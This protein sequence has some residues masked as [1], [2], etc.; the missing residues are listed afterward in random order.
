MFKRQNYASIVVKIG[1]AGVVSF[2]AI[3]TGLVASRKGRNLLR[4]AWQGRKR[5]TLED[6]VL[7]MLWSDPVLSRRPLDVE[8]VADGTVVLSGTVRTDRERRIA[9]ATA[10]QA[11]GVSGVVDRLDVDADL[12]HAGWRDRR[13]ARRLRSGNGMA[14]VS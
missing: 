10:E 5:T 13:E 12:P 8:E 2:G 4:E 6:R 11:R 9:V 7:E 14:P 1:I 3:A